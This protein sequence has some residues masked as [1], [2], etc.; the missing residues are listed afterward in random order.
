MLVRP[1]MRFCFFG[2]LCLI[3]QTAKADGM[4]CPGC[5]NFPA[6]VGSVF[7]QLGKRTAH[8]TRAIFQRCGGKHSYFTFFIDTA[9]LWGPDKPQKI[10]ME[11]G[12]SAIKIISGMWYRIHRGAVIKVY[13]KN[14]GEPQKTRWCRILAI[15]DTFSIELTYGRN[16]LKIQGHNFG[17]TN[18]KKLNFKLN[19]IPYN[20]P[21][22]S[23]KK[24]ANKQA[25]WYLL[26]SGS[27]LSLLFSLFFKKTK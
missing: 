26:V 22:L 6:A 24:Q 19:K 3:M 20:G 27:G 18:Y 2:L 13:A 1:G 16:L 12:D 23:A 11:M 4:A 21:A 7:G 8:N 15:K 10:F 25:L 9:N 5:C 17:A 14:D